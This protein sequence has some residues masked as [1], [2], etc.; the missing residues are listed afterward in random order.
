[1]LKYGIVVRGDARKLFARTFIALL[2]NV[3]GQRAYGRSRRTPLGTRTDMTLSAL[4]CLRLIVIM[5]T[6]QY[7]TLTR[8]LAYDD[9]VLVDVIRGFIDELKKRRG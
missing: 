5:V 1:V 4:E 9:A 3:N 6:K 7:L 8:S 2:R